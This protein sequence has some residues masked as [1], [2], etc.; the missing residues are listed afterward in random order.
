MTKRQMLQIVRNDYEGALL[1]MGF[2]EGVGPA[3][4]Y[5]TLTEQQVKRDRLELRL[6]QI[7]AVMS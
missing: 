5:A 1:D 2:L 3:P 7:D 6:Q 4:E